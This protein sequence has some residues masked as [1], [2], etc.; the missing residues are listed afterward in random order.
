MK[1]LASGSIP[2]HIASMAIQMAIGI[3]VQTLYFFV[4]LYFVSKLGDASIAGVG[5]AGNVW[6]VVLAL[7]QILS[8]G[9]VALVSQ[10][11]GAQQRDVANNVFNQSLLMSGFIGVA[12]IAGVYAVAGPYMRAIGADEATAQAGIDY[13]Y[14]YA[15]GLGLQFLLVAMFATLRATG[16][17]K[18]TM[19]LQ[20]FSVVVNIVLA[21]ML[22]A[23]WGTGKPMGAAGAGLATTIAIVL[24]VIWSAYYF[25]RHEKYVNVHR[26]QLRFQAA[27][28]KRLFMIGLPVGLEFVLIAIVMAV[29]YFVIRDFGAAA[30]AGF[31]IGQ[32]V[33]QMIM[34]PAM[35]VAFS[36]APIAGQNF[37]A[38][39][40]ERVRETFTWG[41][42]ISLAI[43]SVLGVLMWF[44]ARW[45]MQVFTTEE[46][47][48]IVGAQMLMI[49]AF[50][51]PANAVIFS[52]SSLFQALGNTWPTIGSSI[53][54]LVVF[55]G[56][57][58][59]L[60]TRPGFELHHL[61]YLSVC[62][63]FLQAVVSFTLLRREFGR[64]LGSDPNFGRS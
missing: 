16:I 60:S 4:D 10:A 28:W 9:T 41:V 29:I 26:E 44:E 51:F 14:W 42:G 18:P 62:S 3:L 52:C 15:P 39:K 37:G 17:V 35:A 21:P 53:V 33:M 46:A 25:H 8:V 55:I 6:F 13:L 38:R 5:A 64:K 43:M 34:L 23:G 40:L 31:G 63:M 50:N 11:V 24:A 54:R 36:L 22:I 27:V 45:F 61:W 58:L 32:R 2:R 19:Y 59:W 30:Q 48:V 1:D 56:P 47:V 49:S 57:A 20:M 7:T 12:V